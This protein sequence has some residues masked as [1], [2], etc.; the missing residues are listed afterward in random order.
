MNI[1]CHF[2]AV[3]NNEIQHLLKG[4]APEQLCFSKKKPIS[5]FQKKLKIST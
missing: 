2:Y 3:Y 5:L 1:F 4:K